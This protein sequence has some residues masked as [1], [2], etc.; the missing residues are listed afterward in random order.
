MLA[1]GV[2]LYR[3]KDM[4]RG[5]RFAARDADTMGQLFREQGVRLYRLGN[6]HVRV[7]SDAQAT[8]DAIRTAFVELA[9]QIAAQDVFVL[10]LAGHGTSFTSSGVSETPIASGF[11]ATTVYAVATS[12]SRTGI[13]WIAR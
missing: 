3:E 8:G 9:G 10:Y 5:V 13:L 7:L 4:Q 12:T 6:V 11:A 1:I 2:S